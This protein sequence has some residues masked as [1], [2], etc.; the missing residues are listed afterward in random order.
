[1]NNVELWNPPGSEFIYRTHSHGFDSMYG[2]VRHEH[3]HICSR[4]APQK[5]VQVLGSG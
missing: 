1:M 3:L 2:C 5:I 4:Y